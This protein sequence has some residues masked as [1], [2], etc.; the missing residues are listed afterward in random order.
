MEPRPRPHRGA[1]VAAIGA[2]ALWGTTGTAQALGP[3]ESD[4]TSVGTLRIALGAVVLVVLAGPAILS[5]RAAPGPV[6]PPRT[7]R[8]GPPAS[9]V[10]TL[11][12]LA[13]AAYQACFFVGVA[14]TGV[15]VGTVV[16]LGV[17]PVATGALGSLLGERLSSR[18]VV[19]TGTAL[20]GV[21]LLV[22]GTGGGPG[23][24][25]DILGVTAAAGAGVSY[26]AYTVAARS[27]L[28]AGR[29]GVPVMAAFF[30]IGALVLLPSLLRADLAWLATGRG[31]AMVLWLG[32][33]PTALAY[34]LFQRGIAGLPASSVATMSLAEPV[35]ATGL[36]VLVLGERLS[37]LSL[38]GVA[39]VVLGLL[40]VTAGKPHRRG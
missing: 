11:G 20:A 29:R 21:V 32:V 16:A 15:A 36:G 33:V 24:G 34:V 10:T 40:L 26:A 37:G 30:T 1:A 27:L 31:L 13:V 39:A 22:L 12:G 28:L 4:P 23:E 2:A 7:R 18:W 38:L 35:T 9:V 6:G 8:R 25:V 5:R 3:A 14:R 17:A 19:A